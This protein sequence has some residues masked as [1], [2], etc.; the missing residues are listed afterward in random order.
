M[1]NFRFHSPADWSITH[2]RH[3]PGALCSV[4]PSVVAAFP[5]WVSHIL[6]YFETHKYCMLLIVPKNILSRLFHINE[7]VAFFGTWK[8]GFMA[9]VAVGATNVGSIVADFD[10]ELKTNQLGKKMPE[11]E[12]EVEY[13]TPISFKKGDDFGYFNFGSTMVVIFEA[14]ADLGLRP[15][16]KVKMGEPLLV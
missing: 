11:Y 5:G 9:M 13:K 1:H 4:Q 15:S 16:E 7:R 3:F 14:P 10:P 8:H 2:R 12:H 6:V